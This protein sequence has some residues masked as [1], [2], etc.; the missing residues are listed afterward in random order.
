MRLVLGEGLVDHALGGGVHAGIGHRIEP[1]LQ[2]SIQIVK[3][4][5]AAREEEVLADIAIG[6]LDLA[7]SGTL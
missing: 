6:S 3:I 4:A 2:L 5:E 7:A 1:M